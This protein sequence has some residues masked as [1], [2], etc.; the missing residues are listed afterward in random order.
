MFSINLCMVPNNLVKICL[1]KLSAYYRIKQIRVYL[2]LKNK[3]IIIKN[4]KTREEF[5]AYY[6]LRFHVLREPWGQAKGTEKDDYEPISDHFMAV[7]DKNGEIVGAVKLVEKEPGVGQF[8]QMAVAPSRQRQGIGKLLIETVEN[9]ARS[10]GYKTIGIFTHLIST[11]FY[12]KF[13]YVTRGIPTHF[14]GTT[15]LVWMEKN[16]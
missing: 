7:D 1:K 5:K 16:L 10:H 9:A 3:M 14:F 11:G 8:S 15:Q 2:R 4:P 6:A 12:A 13:G